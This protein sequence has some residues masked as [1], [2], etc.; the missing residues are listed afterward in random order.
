MV[1]T[2]ASL[3]PEVIRPGV[4]SPK[5]LLEI[6][7]H[8]SL[9]QTRGYLSGLVQQTVPNRSPK[10]FIELKFSLYAQPIGYD[11]PILSIL[12]EQELMYPALVTAE[13]FKPECDR[14]RQDVLDGNLNLPDLQDST[15]GVCEIR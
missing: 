1:A 3:W 4:Q 15:P 9:E 2:V 6:Q 14:N 5:N 13:L 10:M 12:H 7:A 11:Y 8:A